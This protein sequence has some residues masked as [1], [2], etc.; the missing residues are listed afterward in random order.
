MDRA[1]RYLLAAMAFCMVFSCVH[2][3]EE[4]TI[5]SISPSGKDAIPG[6]GGTAEFKVSC[7]QP[8]EVSF[9]DGSWASLEEQKSTATTN[10][11]LVTLSFAMNG[12][13]K[14][15][16]DT[17]IVT[18]GSKRAV[19]TLKQ[20]TLGKS[21][22]GLG[23]VVLSGVAKYSVQIYLESDWSI[24]VSPE[25]GQWLEV[26][27]LSGSGPSTENI[28]FQAKGLNPD[29]DPRSASVSLS[30]GSN[31]LNFKVLQ[32]P[33]IPTKDFNTAG[34]GIYNYDGA[35]NSIAYN[36]YLHQ[37]VVIK[38][39]SGIF[40]II[41]P[42]EGTFLE[43]GGL[44]EEF[45]PGQSVTFTLVQNFTSSLSSVAEITAVVAGMDDEV[46]RLV[47]DKTIG[48]VLER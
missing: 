3:P 1:L 30:I 42:F 16:V 12:T 20:Y 5:L 4:P 7:D 18:S 2:A 9:H 41:S 22:N 26:S 11:S 27:P 25:D 15:R 40:R 23:D 44:P 39:S 34:P 45:E 36:R 37:T 43:F 46:V 48:Y 21:M 24:R 33:G 14:E 6:Y 35:G 28:V 19:A 17:L 10:Q 38:G 29:A 47:D 8:F 32:N 31:T 13:D